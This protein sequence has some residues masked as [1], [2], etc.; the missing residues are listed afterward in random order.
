MAIA[1]RPKRNVHHKRRTGK[2]HKHGKPYLKT[3]WP[4]I[5][6]LLI[7]GAGFMINTLW[8]NGNVLGDKSNLTGAYLLQETNQSRAKESQQPLSIDNQLN[9]AAQAKAEDMAK[10]DYW[11]HNSP[12]GKTPWTFI[13]G[14][15]YQYQSAGENLAYGFSEASGVIGGWM[16]STEHRS[17]ILN[18]SYKHVGFGVATSLNFQGKG[19]QTIVVAEYGQPVDAVA[20]I[21]FSVPETAQN[22]PTSVKGDTTELNA[23]PVSR[24]EA[25]TGGQATWSAL[26]VSAI[27]GAAL[28]LFLVRHGRRLHKVLA[29]G[30]RF[31]AHHPLLDIAAVFVFTAGFVLTRTTGIIG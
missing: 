7:V 14:S 13:G 25:L 12:D 1:S 20:N 23:Q 31:V 15:G 21:S 17:N 19:P 3:Y 27:A 11:A 28:A 2:H 18:D 16:N 6:M 10:R 4:Y 24:I 22:S 30:E 9:A 8:S 26:L 5:P 29:Q